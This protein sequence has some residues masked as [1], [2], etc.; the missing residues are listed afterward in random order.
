M[1]QR[2]PSSIS[3]AIQKWRDKLAYL[4]LEKARTAGSSQK[5]E[6]QEQIKECQQEI[7]RLKNSCI[8]LD[9]E[10]QLPRKQEFIK[11][12]KYQNWN[13]GS[14]DAQT[15]PTSKEVFIIYSPKD[16][17]MLAQLEM[18]LASLEEEGIIQIWHEGKIKAGQRRLVWINER[19]KSANII[20]LLVSRRFIALDA[21]HKHYVEQARQRHEAEGVHVIPI[22]LSSVPNWKRTWFGQLQL[23][24]KNEQPVSGGNWSNQDVAFATIAE[25]FWEIVEELNG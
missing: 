4:E 15:T 7:Q 16:S 11:T 23:L 9:K 10:T 5:F 20:L 6:L 17:K 18:S 22:L 13:A 14:E 12:D 25:E 3:D 24:P 19:L 1:S 21:D 2:R 8:A